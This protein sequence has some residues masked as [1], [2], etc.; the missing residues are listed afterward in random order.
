MN[1][2]LNNKEAAAYIGVSHN[3]LDVWRSEKRYSLPYIKVG[4][5]IYY[6]KRDLDAWLEAQTVRE[7]VV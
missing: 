4:S 2:R 5:K 6:W 1:D 7:G 3:T